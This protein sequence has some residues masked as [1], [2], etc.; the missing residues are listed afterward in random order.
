MKHVQCHVCMYEYSAFGKV[1][2][3]CPLVKVTNV[4]VCMAVVQLSIYDRCALWNVLF[5]RLYI[6]GYFGCGC[7]YYI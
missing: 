3:V 4:R 2:H 5:G 7:Y 1:I 6:G